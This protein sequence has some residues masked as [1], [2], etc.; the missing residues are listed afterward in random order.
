MALLHLHLFQRFDVAVAVHDAADLST[1]KAQEL[2]CYLLVFRHRAHHREA[3]ADQLWADGSAI[4]AKKN[5]RQALWQVNR[6]LA[7]AAGNEAN[8]LLADKDWVQVNS[9]ASFWLD[10]AEFEAAYQCAKGVQGTILSPA[11]AKR[12]DAAV[13]LYRGHLLE[14]WYQDWCLTERARLHNIYLI[15]LDKLLRHAE[16]RHD[17]EAGIHY[18]ALALRS[19]PAREST[20]RRLMRLHLQAGHRSAALNQYDRCIVALRDEL[21]V[22]PD[23]TTQSLYATICG[24]GTGHAGVGLSSGHLLRQVDEIQATINAL[25]TQL[26]GLR[27]QIGP[28]KDARPY[29]GIDAAE[30]TA[31]LH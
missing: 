26:D 30:D 20:H 5:L 2:L 18:G 23:Q 9:G 8:V 21:A 28:A 17:Y 4:S 25:Q 24:G 10:L 16:A 1:Q 15:M 29:A 14:G 19:D 11:Q 12:L 27:S 13:K 7:D 22:T 31:P 3:L 6:F